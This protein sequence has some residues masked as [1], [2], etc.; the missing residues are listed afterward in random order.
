MVKDDLQND[1]DLAEDNLL[2]RHHGKKEVVFIRN[3]A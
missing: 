1:I 2:C 3:N